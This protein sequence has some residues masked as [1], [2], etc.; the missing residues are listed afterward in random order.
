MEL[1]H[2]WAHLPIRL[3]ATRRYQPWEIRE[4]CKRVTPP[5]FLRVEGRLIPVFG[6]PCLQLA[7]H[8]SAAYHDWLAYNA[9][10]DDGFAADMAE[11]ERKIHAHMEE[12][13]SEESEDDDDE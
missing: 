10:G 12:P 3:S 9:L 8:V 11:R 2:S 13:S 5:F 1:C 7:C 4:K 6:E